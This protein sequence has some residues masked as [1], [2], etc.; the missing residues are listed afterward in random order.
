M[1]LDRPEGP[2]REVPGLTQESRFTLWPDLSRLGVVGLNFDRRLKVHVCG[3]LGRREQVV[4]LGR[5]HRRT[6]EGKR[7]YD[8][9]R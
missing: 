3:K 6:S 7:R 1:S 8:R 9:A 4:S 2:G 5:R